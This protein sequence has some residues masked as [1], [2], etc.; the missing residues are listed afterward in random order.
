[1]V[2]E[3]AEKCYTSQKSFYF[4]KLLHIVSFVSQ[5]MI[6]IIVPLFDFFLQFGFV[7]FIFKKS[8]TFTFQHILDGSLLL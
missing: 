6:S 7:Q 2:F 8:S 4:I 5:V 3:V 1:M